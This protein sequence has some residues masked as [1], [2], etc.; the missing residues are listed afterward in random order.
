[1]VTANLTVSSHPLVAHYV[2][3]LRDQNTDQHRFVALS[4]RIASMLGYEAFCDLRLVSSPVTT[5]VGEDRGAQMIADEVVLVPILRAGL[6]LIP[7][8]QDL[9][10]HTRLCSVGLRRNE[11]TLQPS[12]Y[13]DGLPDE[14]SE[15]I[16]AICDPMLATGGSLLKVIEM[17]KE[18]GAT[19][20]R[21]ICLIGSTPGS[22][23]I[24]DAHP[25][26]R[27]FVGAI[28]EVLNEHGYMI[29]GLGDAGD[30][31]FGPQSH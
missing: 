27:V 20:I 18:R 29:P 11:E 19:D 30:R 22:Q 1:V 17:V 9:L 7:A 21:A 6:A 16:I 3:Q 23:A 8:L 12:V 2:A 25:D 5:P 24:Y 26:V 10:P 28:D 13:L 31:L 15:S 4:S 14:L